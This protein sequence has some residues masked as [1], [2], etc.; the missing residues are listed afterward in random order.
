MGLESSGTVVVLFGTIIG[1]GGVGAVLSMTRKTDYALVALAGLA[2]AEPTGLS[3]RQLSQ[4]YR[5]PLPVLRNILKDLTRAGL[6]AS[7]QGATGGYAL[8]RPPA[9]ITIQRVA[10]AI[11]GPAR[12]AICCQEGSAPGSAGCRLED[13]CLIKSAI[14][15]V[16]GRIVALLADVSIAELAGLH[17]PDATRRHLSIAHG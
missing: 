6:V 9:Q 12:L 7:R 17:A 2:R 3:A 1:P 8:A 4:R 13:S 15:Q 14:Q 10:E 16:H 5:L 11:E